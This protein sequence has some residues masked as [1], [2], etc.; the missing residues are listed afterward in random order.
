MAGQRETNG[1]LRPRQ[2]S[3]AAAKVYAVMMPDDKSARRSSVSEKPG[4]WHATS[5]SAA[6]A[7]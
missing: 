3:N 2:N 5:H 6:P 7:N 1:S 4:I